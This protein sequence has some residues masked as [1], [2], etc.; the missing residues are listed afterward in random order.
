[1]GGVSSTISPAARIVLAT[2]QNLQQSPRVLATLRLP[3]S[4]CSTVPSISSCMERRTDPRKTVPLLI[5]LGLVI[6]QCCQN[7]VIVQLKRMRFA[8]VNCAVVTLLQ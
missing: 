2:S 3:P 5:Y 7:S 4:A 6:Y 1:M 8:S